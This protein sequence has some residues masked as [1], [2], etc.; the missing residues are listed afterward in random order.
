MTPLDLLHFAISTVRMVALGAELLTVAL[1]AA[2]YRGIPLVLA[3]A[4]A[5]YQYATT[6]AH[7]IYR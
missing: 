4:A 5:S 2:L 1:A 6:L 3:I 7:D